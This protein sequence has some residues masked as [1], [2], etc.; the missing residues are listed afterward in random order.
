MLRKNLYQGI[1]V[2]ALVFGTTLVGCNNGTSNDKTSKDDDEY[3][4]FDDLGVIDNRLL[5][6]DG[7]AWVSKPDLEPVGDREGYIFL[8]DGSVVLFDDHDSPSEGNWGNFRVMYWFTSESNTMVHLLNKWGDTI[9][10]AY[11]VVDD[12]L[13]LDDE[14]YGKR[15]IDIILIP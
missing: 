2:M 13:T 3:N 15:P 5:P 1:L 6:G 4:V 14:K 8:S 11:T 9:D 10:I 7:H 12:V